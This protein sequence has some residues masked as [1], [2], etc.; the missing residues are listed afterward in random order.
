MKNF[1]NSLSSIPKY[2]LDYFR[3]CKIC[4]VTSDPDL[5]DCMSDSKQEDYDL[6]SNSQA[7]HHNHY[8]Y[9]ML[10]I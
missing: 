1:K 6:H 2:D 8:Y 10:L 5:I 7:I 3:Y 4:M 9:Y